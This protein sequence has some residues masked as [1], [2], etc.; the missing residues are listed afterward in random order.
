MMPDFG[1]SRQPYPRAFLRVPTRG[2]GRPAVRRFDY[3]VQ[4]MSRAGRGEGAIRLGWSLTLPGDE[5]HK[6]R[7]LRP[8]PE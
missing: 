8:P 5:L 6:I 7:L 4:A 3:I 1:K 2:K